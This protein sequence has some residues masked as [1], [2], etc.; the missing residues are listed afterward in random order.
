MHHVS[1]LV[2]HCVPL[3]SQG[4]E[5]LWVVNQ[6]LH[7]LAKAIMSDLYHNFLTVPLMLYSQRELSDWR[8]A[9]CTCFTSDYCD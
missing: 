1:T 6:W 8:R 3:S 7:M 2:L 9:V 4:C 5:F